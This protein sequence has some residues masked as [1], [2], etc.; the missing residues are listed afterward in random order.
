MAAT[1]EPGALIG[2]SDEK[3]S[4]MMAIAEP[5]PKIAAINEDAST[6]FRRIEEN[7]PN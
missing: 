2:L 7:V 6:S 5:A 1:S 3:A 4:R